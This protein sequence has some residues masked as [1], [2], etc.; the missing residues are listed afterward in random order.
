MQ[1]PHYPP[2]PQVHGENFHLVGQTM[3]FNSISQSPSSAYRRATPE[4]AKQ[5]TSTYD[6]VNIDTDLV[7][8]NEANRTAKKRYWTAEEEERLGNH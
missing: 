8:N 7:D 6:P 3:S 1:Q 5:G 4:A 2:Q